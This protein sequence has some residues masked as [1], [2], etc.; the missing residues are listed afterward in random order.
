MSFFSQFDTTADVMRQIIQ[1]GDTGAM[2]PTFQRISTIRCRLSMASIAEREIQ[3]REGV[4]S[5][6]TAVAEPGVNVLSRD[7]LWVT[8]G[9]VIQKYLVN[10]VDPV[11]VFLTIHHTRIQATL[12]E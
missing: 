1:Q 7:Q 12:V 9:N 6:H 3:S 11:K 5:T 4:V 8:V 10:T 2:K